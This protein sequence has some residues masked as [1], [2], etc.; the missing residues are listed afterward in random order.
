MESSPEPDYSKEPTRPK[1]MKVN[2][3]QP[4]NAEPPESMLI[5]N[6]LTPTEIFLRRNH[7]PIPDVKEEEYFVKVT[8]LVE[9]P[10]KLTV[11]DLKAHFDFY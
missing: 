9:N 5:E 3:P 4:Y 6:F 10:G 11:S 1:Y 8:G 7:G 2:C